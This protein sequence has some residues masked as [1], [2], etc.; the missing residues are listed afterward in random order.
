MKRGSFVNLWEPVPIGQ[1][2]AACEECG[3]C[4]LQIPLHHRHPADSDDVEDA[5][6]FSN[7][8]GTVTM[9]IKVQP[10]RPEDCA[11][12]AYQNVQKAALNLGQRADDIKTL[13]MT[14]TQFKKSGISQSFVNSISKLDAVVS[15]IDKVAEVSL[16]ILPSLAF[17]EA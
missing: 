16:C 12:L 2:A 10:C 7:D 15:V 13:E 17:S 3:E 8:L 11:K 9:S 4:K 5:T 14:A 1:L 6:F